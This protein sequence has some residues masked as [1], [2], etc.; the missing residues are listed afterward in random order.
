MRQDPNNNKAM[1]G[2]LRRL[3]V[4][5]VIFPSIVAISSISPDE[6]NKPHH[7][8]RQVGSRLVIPGSPSYL[9]LNPSF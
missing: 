5:A 1:L 2:F 8:M 6:L 7:Q 3:L 4:A 9:D